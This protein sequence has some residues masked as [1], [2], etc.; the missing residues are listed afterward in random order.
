MHPSV[1]KW[2]EEKIVQHGLSDEAVLEVGSLNVNGSVR[3]LFTSSAY[4]GVDMREGPDVDFVMNAH[5]L[6]FPDRS[7]SVVI[8]CE[9][10]EHDD[11]PW[12]SMQEMARVS[13]GWVILTARGYD[14]RGC[15][16]LHSYPDDLYRYSVGGITAMMKWAGIKPLEV[17]E[18]YTDPGFFAIGTV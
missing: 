11:L 7:A 14:S 9:M 5:D 6:R 1:M 15:F 16:P 17:I 2:V 4:I 10:L 13:S 3:P 12:V 18:D 8:S